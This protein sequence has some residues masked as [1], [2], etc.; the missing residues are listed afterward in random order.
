MNFHYR[1]TALTLFFALTSMTLVR[2]EIGS[3]GIGGTEGTTSIIQELTFDQNT[4]SYLPFIGSIG[5]TGL[6]NEFVENPNIPGSSIEDLDN[7]VP[8]TFEHTLFISYPNST[9]ATEG[10]RRSAVSFVTPFENRLSNGSLAAGSDPAFPAASVVLFEFGLNDPAGTEGVLG[11]P[12][13]LDAF[14]FE[15]DVENGASVTVDFIQTN[16]LGDLVVHSTDPIGTGGPAFVGFDRLDP[17]NGGPTP[18]YNFNKVQI[19][20]TPTGGALPQVA[21]YIDNLQTGGNIEA[22]AVPEPSS[23]A[24]ALMAGGGW[25]ARRVRRKKV[26]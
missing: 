10:L 12:A 14:A 20:A 24:F 2:A 5:Q 13:Y 23:F 19:T 16:S 1:A 21:Y 11:A 9:D 26:A 25:V 7:P 3:G 8:G 18:D 17:T 15:L 22:A 6:I 4:D